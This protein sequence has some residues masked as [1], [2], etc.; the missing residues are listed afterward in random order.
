MVGVRSAQSTRRAYERIEAMGHPDLDVLMGALVWHTQELRRQR[1]H[2]EDTS[3]CRVAYSG[4]LL[5]LR[6]VSIG[7]SC[8][9][10]LAD[11]ALYV[12]CLLDL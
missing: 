9:C 10:T 7:V 4:R 6:E 5:D 2:L 12:A 8:A 11:T 3:M 1:T